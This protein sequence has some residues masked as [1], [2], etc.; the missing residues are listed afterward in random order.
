M[1][2]SNR[3]TV[4]ISAL[5]CLLLVSTCATA[6]GERF[7]VRLHVEEPTGVAR[8]AWPISGGVPLPPGRFRKGQAFAL[9]GQDDKELPC[10]VSPLVVDN[11]VTSPARFPSSESLAEA[12]SP[13]AFTLVMKFF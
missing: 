3:P 11:Q 13:A 12:V 5:L 9:F 2:Q 8:K 4:R 1:N 10:Q 7:E 6:L